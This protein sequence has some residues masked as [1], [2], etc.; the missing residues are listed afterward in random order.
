MTFRSRA[1][2]LLALTGLASATPLHQA[3][4]E[5]D[6]PQPPSVS[7]WDSWTDTHGVTHLTKCKLSNFSLSRLSPHTDPL[8]TNHAQK[9]MARMVTSVQP[10][11]W[12]GGW[13][14]PENVQWIIPLMGIW[15]V[16]TMDGTRVELNP[17]DALLSED[18]KA[19]AD[20]KGHVGHLSG[21]V[22]DGPVALMITQFA[23]A[24]ARNKP[25]LT[26]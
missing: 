20:S 11:H 3:R 5:T 6:Q 19:I 25:C 1:F 15:Y 26:R 23:S 12:E 13:H 18:V 4:A 10:A 17:G 9:G 7:Y 24:H 16:E 21:N 14:A 2:L 22:G 8:W